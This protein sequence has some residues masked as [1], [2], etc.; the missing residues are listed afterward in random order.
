MPTLSFSPLTYCPFS[1]APS[2]H[3]S[4]YLSRALPFPSLAYCLSFPL[5]T[6]IYSLT[7]RI[8][9]LLHNLRK[10][11]IYPVTSS[12]PSLL[13]FIFPYSPS[14]LLIH[15]LFLLLARPD[16]S[17]SLLPFPLPSLPTLYHPSL[18]LRGRHTSETL[19]HRV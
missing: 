2:F 13:T 18:H 8:Y 14:F 6:D 12:P 9:S 11:L 7:H 10:W 4:T 17:T 1:N 3:L 5:F 19:H 15:S 16:T